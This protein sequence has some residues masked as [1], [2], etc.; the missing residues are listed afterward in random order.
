M[1][2]SSTIIFLKEVSAVI[3][4]RKITCIIGPSGCGKSTLLKSLNRLLDTNEEVHISGSVLVDGGRIVCSGS[5][6]YT[7]TA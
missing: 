7:Y 2:L 6:D 3:P 1:S 5:R 4:D